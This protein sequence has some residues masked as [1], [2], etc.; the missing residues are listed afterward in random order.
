MDDLHPPLCLSL[1]FTQVTEIIEILKYIF[2]N[3]LIFFSP[4]FMTPC[5]LIDSS[6]AVLHMKRVY[7][8]I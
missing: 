5:H 2:K 1:S 6:L 7:A 4:I 3:L 8:C